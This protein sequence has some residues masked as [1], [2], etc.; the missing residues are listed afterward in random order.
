MYGKTPQHA[1]IAEHAEIFSGF[2][3]A[4][5]PVQLLAKNALSR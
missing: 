2:S 3:A 1:E 5:T 4:L